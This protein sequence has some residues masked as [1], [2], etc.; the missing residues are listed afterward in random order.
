MAK[1][2]SLDKVFKL[3]EELEKA[4]KPAIEALLAQ[5]AELDSKLASLGYFGAQGG[6]KKTRAPKTC[7]VCGQQ[8]HTSRKCPSKK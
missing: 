3:M 4:K 8:G 6:G 1:D 7:S 2:D 5:R